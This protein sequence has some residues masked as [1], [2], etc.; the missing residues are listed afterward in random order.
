M[1]SFITE[2]NWKKYYCLDDYFWTHKYW[3]IEFEDGDTWLSLDAT[4]REVLKSLPKL[5]IKVEKDYIK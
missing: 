3:Y 1:S 2:V 4:K 5:E